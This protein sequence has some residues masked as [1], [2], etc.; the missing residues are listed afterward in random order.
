M[1]SGEKKSED[2]WFSLAIPVIMKELAVPASCEKG[3]R[4]MV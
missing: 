2:D 4:L 1:I 3:P